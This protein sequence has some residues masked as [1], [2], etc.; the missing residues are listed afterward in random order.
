MIIFSFQISRP[1]TCCGIFTLL[2]NYCNILEDFECKVPLL[3]FDR[4]VKYICQLRCWGFGLYGTLGYGSTD[5]IGDKHAPSVAGVVS[6][7]A[8]VNSVACSA[9][10]SC[11]ATNT[12]EVCIAAFWYALFWFRSIFLIHITPWC[13]CESCMLCI[14]CI[15]GACKIQIMGD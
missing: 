2:C 8:H 13:M 6:I 5:N 12:G 9:H 15:A 7:A 1:H 14:R 10:H 11:A 3:L 4:F